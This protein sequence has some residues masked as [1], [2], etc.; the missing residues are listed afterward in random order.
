MIANYTQQ[1]WELITQRAH[2]LLAAQVALYWKAAERP[3]RWMETLLAIAEHDDAMVELDGEQLLT[4]AGGP[5]NFTMKNFELEHC[6]RL[7]RFSRSKSRYIALLTSMHMDFIYRKDM[8]ADPKAKAFL[9]EQR[10]LQATWRRE[11]G[12]S[13]EDAEKTYAFMEWCDAFSLL[14]CQHA[15]QPES[16]AI[17]IS[18]GPDKRKYELC[19][20]GE[21]ELTL[22]P[23]PFEPDR[24]D[25]YFESRVVPQLQFNSSDELRAAFLLAQVKETRWTLV[26]SKPAAPKPKVKAR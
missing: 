6:I 24:F 7:S 16:R 9:Q 26:K 2:G 10:S 20:V 1:G 14:L 8:E 13:K 18:R 23:W 17:E 3:R 22:L 15:V 11:L 5:I 21:G 4:E 25:V 12:L 19:Q